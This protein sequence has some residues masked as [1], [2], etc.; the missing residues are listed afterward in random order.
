M[1]K[2]IAFMLACLM[3]LSGISVFAADTTTHTS[4]LGAAWVDKSNI[5]TGGT[6]T[7]ETVPN[8]TVYFEIDTVK[9]EADIGATASKSVNSILSDS[10]AFK[11]TAKK[12]KNSQLIKSIKLV[13]KKI[14][15]VT[16]SG[17]GRK[18]YLAVEL[19]SVNTDKE[20]AVEFTAT[21][22]AVKNL[23]ITVPK[24]TKFAGTGK[25]Y[26]KNDEITGNTTLSVG[27]DAMVKPEENEDNEVIWESSTNEVARLTFKSSSNPEAFSAKLSTKWTVALANKFADTNAVIR[28]FSGGTVDATSRPSLYLDNPF[29]SKV[30]TDRIKIYSVDSKGVITDVTKSFTHLSATKS[31]SG[32]DCFRIRTRTLGTYIISDKAIKLK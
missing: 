9:G 17:Q 27:V 4:K 8:K 12:G 28:R 3:M 29:S 24:G 7:Y 15:D 11:F 13:D 32:E 2:I 23:S 16:G 22:R 10:T 25:L 5:G 6:Q 21:F 30:K 1:K 18:T 31:P 20:Y 26:V 19:G 14:S